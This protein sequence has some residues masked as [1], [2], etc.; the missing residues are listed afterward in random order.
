MRKP[1]Y[2]AELERALLSK[3]AALG[4][5][6]DGDLIQVCKDSARPIDDRAL[7]CGL[8][9]QMRSRASLPVLLEVGSTENETLLMWQSLAAVGAVGSRTA[10]RRLMELARR[11]PSHIRRQ[12]AVFALGM[13]HDERARSLL[14]HLL[15]DVEQDPKTRGLAAEALGL[16]RPNAQS[17]RA[18]IQVLGRGSGEVRYSALCGIGALRSKAALPTLRRLLDDPTIASEEHPI[19]EVAARIVKD[20]ED[21]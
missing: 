1:R 10:T 16:L 19:A 9:G 14:I 18:L 6:T 5:S 2:S 13:L 11:T 7:A 12:A 15:L 4:A 17:T 20:I 3:M 21:A 8:L